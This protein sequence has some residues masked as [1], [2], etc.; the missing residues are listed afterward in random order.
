[1]ILLKNFFILSHKL[2]VVELAISQP[3]KPQG[4]KKSC[5]TC[6]DKF[7]AA[8][9]ARQARLLPHDISHNNHGW[10]A[11]TNTHAYLQLCSL[12]GE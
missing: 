6:V 12:L 7:H 1:M 9:N 8:W 5:V 10:P 3:K 4:E 2:C 11:K